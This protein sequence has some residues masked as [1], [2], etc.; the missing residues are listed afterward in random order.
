MCFVFSLVFLS[1]S[2]LCFSLLLLSLS[3]S[4]LP[5]CF[6]LSL[7]SLCSLSICS[8]YLSRF[9]LSLG[10]LLYFLSL[11]RSVLSHHAV[12]FLLSLFLSAQASMAAYGAALRASGKGEGK[13]MCTEIVA[14]PH[15]Y[16]VPQLRRWFNIVLTLFW[17]H[18]SHSSQLCTSPHPRLVNRVTRF[19]MLL[20]DADSRLQSDGVPD[21]ALQA[22]DYHQQYLAKPGNRQYCSAMPT[23]QNMPPTENWVRTS[24]V[25]CFLVCQSSNDRCSWHSKDKK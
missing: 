21:S 1:L 11:S 24:S 9:S 7:C 12:L 18:F 5:P 19:R 13:S 2:L 6:S 15:F 14:G 22:E 23:S 17:D 4:V 20:S 8:L 10:S 25:L 16:Y 3:L